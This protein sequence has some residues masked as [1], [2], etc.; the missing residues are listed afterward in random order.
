MPFCDTFVHDDDDDDVF[1]VDAR[2]NTGV[3]ERES[4]RGREKKNEKTERKKEREIER[5]SARARE[6]KRER[7]IIIV[8]L[9]RE[10][11]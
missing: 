7:V 2:D 8:M 6:R 11:K 10:R 5:E 1:R 4:T 3:C 9:G